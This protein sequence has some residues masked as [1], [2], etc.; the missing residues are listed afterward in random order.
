MKWNR[1]VL[2]KLSVVLAFA[3]IVVW[4]AFG[5]R[6]FIHLYRMEKQRQQYR[7]RIQELEQKNHD[8]LLEIERL[9]TDEA[10]IESLARKELNLLKEDEVHYHFA[11]KTQSGT[12]SHTGSNAPEKGGPVHAAG[13]SRGAKAPASN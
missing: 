12:T 7:E 13:S 3:L 8:L 2:T 1:K 9:R 4:L 6:G 10:Y 5:K 11:D